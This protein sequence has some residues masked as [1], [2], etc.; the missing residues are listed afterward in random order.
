ML[1]GTMS[2]NCYMLPC[3]YIATC[4]H[5]NESLHVTMAL[6]GAGYHVTEELEFTPLIAC[7]K[8]YCHLNNQSSHITLISQVSGKYEV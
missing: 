1:Q 5:V 3:Q 2:L 7:D 8:L 4:Y 6:D